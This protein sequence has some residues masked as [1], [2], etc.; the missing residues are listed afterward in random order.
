MGPEKLWTLCYESVSVHQTRH[1][2]RCRK[3]IQFQI[4]AKSD[5]N[6]D[7][8]LIPIRRSQ[9]HCNFNLFLIKVN[10]FWSIFNKKIDQSQFKEWKSGLKDQNYWL[11]DWNW[12]YLSKLIY[13]DIFDPF[14]SISI[15]YRLKSINFELFD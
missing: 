11:R 14:R 6:Y 3:P 10:R 12:R 8:N 15:S 2:P 4:P 5:D 1:I 9:F 7:T 13:F